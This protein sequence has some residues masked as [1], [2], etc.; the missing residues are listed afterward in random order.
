[1]NQRAEAHRSCLTPEEAKRPKEDFFAG[2]A[3]NCRYE[4]FDMGSG[5]IDAVMK[6]TERARARR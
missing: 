6:C 2:A 5:K 4:R 3:K 1:M